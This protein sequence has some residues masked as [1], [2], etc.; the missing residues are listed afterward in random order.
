MF[1][2]NVKNNYQASHNQYNKIWK[3]LILIKYEVDMNKVDFLLDESDIMTK[4][5]FIN[6]ENFDDNILDAYSLAVTTAAEKA[7]RLS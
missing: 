2:L 3:Q 5:D 6:N 7:V 4:P 1:N